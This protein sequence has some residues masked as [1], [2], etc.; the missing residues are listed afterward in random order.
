MSRT[1]PARSASLPAAWAR[2][3]STSSSPT[4]PSAASSWWSR[5]TTWSPRARRW[6]TE[7]RLRRDVAGELLEDRH[8]AVQVLVGVGDRERPLLLHARG[9]E[10]ATVHVV[11]PPEGGELAVD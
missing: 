2:P 4:P 7:R 5:P 3:A 1:G 11:E 6:P 8:V 10:D 9:H